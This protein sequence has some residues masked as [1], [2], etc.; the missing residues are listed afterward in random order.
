MKYIRLTK[1]AAR[2]AYKDNKPVIIVPVKTS[3]ASV[4]FSYTAQLSEDGIDFDNFV[5][6]FRF[7]YCNNE[8]GR[9]PAYYR[10]EV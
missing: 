4:M 2:A 5:N 8:L 9:Y 1:A 10:T 6:Q 7:Y 3:P